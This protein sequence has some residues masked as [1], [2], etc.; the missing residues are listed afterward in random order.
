MIWSEDLLIKVL[1]CR[2]KGRL[3]NITGYSIDTRTLQKGDIFFAFSGAT[4]DGH[5]FLSIAEQKGASAAIVTYIPDECADISLPL[6][7]VKSVHD[8]MIKMAKY[9]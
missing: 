9:V 7:V 6:I 2:I 3:G 5:K 1:Q 8:S 4:V